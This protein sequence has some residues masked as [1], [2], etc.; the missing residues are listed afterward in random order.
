MANAYKLICIF[1]VFS[2]W[3]GAL[4]GNPQNPGALAPK[5]ARARARARPLSS[6]AP[7]FVQVKSSCRIAKYHQPQH[8]HH[9]R[10]DEI[11]RT[12]LLIVMRIGREAVYCLVFA[13]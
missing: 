3:S 6:K 12:H 9:R 2:F 11:A 8:T 7:A 5:R 13:S 10:D 4:G 1:F